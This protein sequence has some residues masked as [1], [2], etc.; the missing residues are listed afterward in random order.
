MNLHEQR[1]PNP[2]IPN[3]DYIPLA[4]VGI[5]VGSARL[6]IG[7]ARLQVR[8]GRLRV[9]FLDTML[10]SARVGSLEKCIGGL[11][12]YRA[13]L[14]RGCDGIQALLYRLWTGGLQLFYCTT[15]VM[16]NG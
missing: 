9:G 12:Q 8:S 5:R 14:H 1:A 16:V 13:I 4:C 3:A 11:D 7:S 2:C 15:I 10:V 6:R